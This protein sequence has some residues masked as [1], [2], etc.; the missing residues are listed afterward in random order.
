MHTIPRHLLK[1]LGPKCLP[2]LAY[3]KDGQAFSVEGEV[4]GT[5]QDFADYRVSLETIHLCPFVAQRLPQAITEKW[6]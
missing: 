5:V 3:E 2:L 4:V 6:P 1:G